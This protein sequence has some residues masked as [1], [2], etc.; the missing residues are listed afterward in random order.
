M[1]YELRPSAWVE[2]EGDW[3]A[4]AVILAEIPS[5]DEF[6]DNIVAY[7]RPAVPLG[8]GSEVRYAYRVSFGET[9]PENAPLARVVGTRGGLSI[10]DTRERVFVVDFDLGLIDFATLNPRLEASRGEV[11]G[12]SIQ[13]LPTGNIARV[14]FH[15][16]P[17]EFSRGRVPPLARK[18]GPGGV[19]DLALQVERV[20]SGPV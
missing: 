9:Q 8:P 7:W 20:T 14:G 5:A 12:L 11:K 18:R 2:P 13:K 3:G 15:F 6:T 19:G 4:G 17:G 16:V 1:H 10:L